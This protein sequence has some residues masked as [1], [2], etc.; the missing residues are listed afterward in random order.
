MCSSG[1]SRVRVFLENRSDD[2]VSQ[3]HHKAS[4]QRATNETCAENEQK[5]HVIQFQ[6]KLCSVV[7]RNCSVCCCS[8]VVTCCVNVPVLCSFAVAKSAALSKEKYLNAQDE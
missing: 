4:H 5:H 2:G 8:C 6:N 1:G 7:S 3:A